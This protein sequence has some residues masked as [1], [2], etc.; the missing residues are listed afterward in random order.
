MFKSKLPNIK[1]DNELINIMSSVARGRSVNKPVFIKLLEKMSQDTDNLKFQ[2]IISDI[3]KDSNNKNL[4]C[5]NRAIKNEFRKQISIKKHPTLG[6]SD[7]I[8]FHS[9]RNKILSN[10]SNDEELNNEDNQKTSLESNSSEEQSVY[11]KEEHD[12]VVIDA[13]YKDIQMNEINIISHNLIEDVLSDEKF[14]INLKEINS[15]I[16]TEEIKTSEDLIIDEVMVSSESDDIFKGQ[17]EPELV[18]KRMPIDRARN[19][20]IIGLNP[21]INSNICDIETDHLQIGDDLDEIATE[22]QK[23]DCLDMKQNIEIQ[24]KTNEC[25]N[26]KTYNL[27]EEIVMDNIAKTHDN[28]KAITNSVSRDRWINIYSLD[29]VQRSKFNAFC[30]KKLEGLMVKKNKKSGNIFSNLY[31]YVIS[32]C[33]KNEEIIIAKPE[34]IVEVSP[35]IFDLGRYLLKNGTTT[36]GIFRCSADLKYSKVIPHDIQKGT[37]YDYEKTPIIE[38]AVVFK[39]YIRDVLRG[40]FSLKI[41]SNILRLYKESKVKKEKDDMGSLKEMRQIKLYIQHYMAFTLDASR[42]KLLKLVFELFEQVIKNEDESEINL[43]GLAIIF[44]PNLLPLDCLNEAED[45]KIIPGIIELL[46]QSN[47]DNIYECVYEEFLKTST[48]Q[49]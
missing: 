1:E 14:Y 15:D 35:F 38:N 33:R 39:A 25:E 34:E 11:K 7:L 10:K 37:F 47:M 18:K 9:H 19:K 16:D 22:I 26:E 41:A 3:S 30:S 46:Y 4:Y 49:K 8:D 2:T 13:L 45:Y 17:S 42:L 43:E 27:K 29:Q 48:I 28:D 23:D 40:L 21:D 5:K 6:N 12:R 20:T 36:P 24:P 44:G 31:E 32:C